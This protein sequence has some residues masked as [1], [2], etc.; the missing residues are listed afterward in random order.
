[1]IRAKLKQAFWNF[2]HF[3]CC[4][5][6]RLVRAIVLSVC[7]VVVI[8]QLTE[9]FQK[10]IGPPITTHSRF[11][12][13]DSMLYPAVTFCRDP[14]YKQEVMERYNLTQH[15]KYSSAFN[16]FNFNESS[17]ADLFREATYNKSEFFIQYGLNGLA[18]NVEVISSMHF[19]M[20]QCFTLNP[21][22]TTTH[23]W[24]E[25][26]FSILLLHD[27]RPAEYFLSENLPGW[28]VFIHDQAEGFAE[29]RMQSS[30]RV[31]YL[32]MEVDEEVEVKLTTQHFQMLPSSENDCTEGSEI[33]STRCSELCHWR[34]V[35]EAVGCT[36]PWMPDIEAE[37][38]HTAND[39]QQLI[40]HYKAMED[41][42]STVCGCF[43]PCSSTIFT[44][45]VMNRK[46]INITLPAGQFWLYYT[47]KMVSIVEEF[48]SYDL[49]QFVADLGGS[50]GFLLGLSVLGLIGLLEKI[51]QLVFIRSLIAEKRNKQKI[52]GCSETSITD[53]KGDD[54]S[55]TDASDATLAVQNISK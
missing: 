52:D 20:G 9:C 25:A 22:T 34:H 50:L 35:V 3:L 30:G 39:T 8:F 27:T 26:G 4:D 47:S 44:T 12:L 15:P 51:V 54:F 37:Q 38:C 32:F 7:S 2:L 16:N 18:E 28:H 43:Q 24:K 13:N 31:E 46:S 40:K 48:H 53:K 49:T 45:Y 36:G 17:L 55:Q 42:D 33:S 21:L 14:P 6:K 10:L 41:M 5:P 1:M 19:D 23:S 11:D 29:N